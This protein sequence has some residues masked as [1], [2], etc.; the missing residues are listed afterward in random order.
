MMMS[1]TKRVVLLAG[2]TGLVGGKLLQILLNDPDVARVHALSR[3]PPAIS[4]PNLT[5]HLVDFAS[6]P[7]LPRADEAYLALGTTIKVA[8]SRE[9]FRAVDFDANMAVA[10]A[11]LSAGVSRVGLVS[12]GGANAQSSMFYTRVKGELEQA[13]RA[14]PFTTLVIAQ[15]SLLLDSR[16]GLGQ[17]VRLGEL[18]SIPLARLLSPILPGAYKPIEAL[19]VARALAQQVPTTTGV[20]VLA[21][22]QMIKLGKFRRV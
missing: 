19:A 9:A 5:V 3:K 15:P 8:G 16:H 11:A 13:L 4:H 22:D 2:A 20:V 14:M 12:A 1:E 21:S 10:R 17:P 7:P 18:I 6:L